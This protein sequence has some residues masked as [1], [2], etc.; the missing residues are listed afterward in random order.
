MTVEGMGGAIDGK[1]YID[2]AASKIGSGYTMDLELSKVEG[3][4][5]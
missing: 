1:Y 3:G 4:S 5:L 2:S